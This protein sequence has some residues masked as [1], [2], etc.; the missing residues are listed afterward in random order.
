MRE[1][2]AIAVLVFYDEAYD[3][4]GW[5][6]YDQEYPEDGSCGAFSSKE[7]AISHAESGDYE[8]VE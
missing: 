5:Y 4:P 1:D 2:K 7:E 8:V 3:G 6:Y